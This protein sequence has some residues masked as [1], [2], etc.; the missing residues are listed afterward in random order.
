MTL[1]A[2]PDPPLADGHVTL[3]RWK[4]TDAALVTEASL[5]PYVAE[6]EKLPAPDEA[7]AVGEW[8]ARRSS[9]AD[10]GA[11]WSFVVL[12]GDAHEPVGAISLTIRHPRVAEVG[13]FVLPRARNARCAERAT[14]LVARW[15]LLH[16]GLSR[17]HATVEPWN[18]AS[19]RVLEKAGFVREGLLRSY[20]TLGGR[21][22]DAVMYSLVRS[23]LP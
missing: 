2:Y 22:D 19:Q 12:A 5:D 4:S 23:D 17:V 14:V 15:G 20:V 6:I 21:S 9:T 1:L 8:I 11:G 16:G 18:A 13:C 3:R 10:D 7:D